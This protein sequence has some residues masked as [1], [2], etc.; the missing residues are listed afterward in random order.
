MYSE[1]TLILVTTEN[2]LYIIKGDN[3]IMFVYFF[4]LC[5][6]SNL[7]IFVVMDYPSW[8]LHPYFSH[9][10]EAFTIYALL[11][12]CLNVSKNDLMFKKVYKVLDQSFALT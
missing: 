10:D 9:F 7:T 3:S 11:W 4:V 2:R 6:F 12:Y 8:V 1:T 5:T